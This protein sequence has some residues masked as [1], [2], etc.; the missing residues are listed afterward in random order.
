MH[1]VDWIIVII[2]LLIVAYV[3]F[4]TQKYVKGVS[5][6]LTAGRRRPAWEGHRCSQS[7]T[8]FKHWTCLTELT[9]PTS[10]TQTSHTA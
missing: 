7:S 9:P 8:S 6:F 10:S 4:R 5:D 3:S 1:W 2:P